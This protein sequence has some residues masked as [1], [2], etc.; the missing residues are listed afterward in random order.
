MQTQSTSDAAL[1]APKDWLFLVQ[2]SKNFWFSELL[3]R[4]LVRDSHTFMLLVD[5]TLVIANSS[6]M[7]L[8][9][10]HVSAMTAKH[11]CILHNNK[12]QANWVTYPLTSKDQIF[13]SL[14]QYLDLDYL[15]NRF[16]AIWQKSNKCICMN[17]FALQCLLI[18]SSSHAA[19]S[20]HRHCVDWNVSLRQAAN[21]AHVRGWGKVSKHKIDLLT[22]SVQVLDCHGW[23]VD[24]L[25]ADISLLESR[26]TSSGAAGDDR[27][28]RIQ[29]G[30]KLFWLSR[31]F[32][33]ES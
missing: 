21:T 13:A 10:D 12:R 22:G 6:V 27:N 1:I 20:V 5:V 32:C 3:W 8:W 16:R 33:A 24:P 19:L 11:S 23:Q 31:N 29:D 26:R 14:S 9:A 15:N 28:K 17:S 7:S 25:P 30:R 4:R 2:P 18:K